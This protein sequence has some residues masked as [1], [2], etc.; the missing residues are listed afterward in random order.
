MTTYTRKP[1][2]PVEAIQWTGTEESTDEVFA[3]LGASR[4]GYS[5]NVSPEGVKTLALFT[6]RTR[7]VGEAGDWVIK[8]L[9][10]P[11]QFFVVPAVEFAQTYEPQA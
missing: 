1:I 6:D 10:T 3:F 11:P 7:L 5:V 8:T 9:D 2:E 4:S